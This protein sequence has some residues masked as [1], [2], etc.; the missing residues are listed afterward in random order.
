MVKMS[1]DANVT[2]LQMPAASSVI[3]PLARKAQSLLDIGRAL[4]DQFEV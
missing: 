3:T 1:P 4:S 2:L